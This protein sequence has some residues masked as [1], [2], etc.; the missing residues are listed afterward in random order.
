MLRAK[1]QRILM[2]ANNNQKNLAQL[3]SVR[4][5]SGKI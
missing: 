2:D 5:K 3:V 1:G 4:E